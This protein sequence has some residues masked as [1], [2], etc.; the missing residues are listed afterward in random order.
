MTVGRET[1]ELDCPTLA[2]WR[3][4]QRQAIL[5]W[6]ECDLGLEPSQV[7]LQASPTQV[8]STMVPRR[9]KDVEWLP[10]GE[11]FFAVVRESMKRGINF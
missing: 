11:K 5:H 2:G 3:W 7:G 8:V 9:K 4:A 1:G 10:D 6:D